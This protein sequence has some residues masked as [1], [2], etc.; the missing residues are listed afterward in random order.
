MLWNDKASLLPGNRQDAGMY[1]M[2]GWN[3]ATPEQRRTWKVTA[4]KGWAILDYMPSL[5]GKKALWRMGERNVKPLTETGYPYY[6]IGLWSSGLHGENMKRI[7]VLRFPTKDQD[8]LMDHYQHLGE[9]Q[10]NPDGVHVS[11]IYQRKLYMIRA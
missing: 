8:K 2:T 9:F 11:F 5:D 7:G 1:E 3:L 10:W 6:A 4:P